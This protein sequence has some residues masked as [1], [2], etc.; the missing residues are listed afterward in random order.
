MVGAQRLP[1]AG[2][3]GDDEEEIVIENERGRVEKLN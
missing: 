2:K 1:V 3:H